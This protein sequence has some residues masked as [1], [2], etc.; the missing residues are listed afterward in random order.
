MTSDMG[1]PS[2]QWLHD[3]PGLEDLFLESFFFKWKMMF[4]VLL[5]YQQNTTLLPATFPTI[6]IHQQSKKKLQKEISKNFIFF[7][8]YRN[9]NL[10]RLNSDWNL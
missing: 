10:Y 8:P 2:R 1:I 3:R 5:R 7:Y 4:F 6:R 9:Q